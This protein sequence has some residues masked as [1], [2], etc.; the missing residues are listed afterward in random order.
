ME[1]RWVKSKEF[2]DY[3][4]SNNGRVRNTKTGRIMKTNIN[5]NGYETVCLRKNKQQYNCR[6]HRLIADSFYGGEHDGL[7]VNHIDGNKRNNVISN[8]EFCTRKDN[9]DHALNHGLSTTNDYG[10]H[11]VRVRV[12]DT[13]ETYSSINECSRAI[14]VDHSEIC[15][16]LSGKISYPCKGYRFEKV[17]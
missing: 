9:V 17:D 1:E 5:T 7:D 12:I 13:G 14:G 6:V 10:K 8:L 2:P 11:R 16:Y 15:K 3:E 4:V